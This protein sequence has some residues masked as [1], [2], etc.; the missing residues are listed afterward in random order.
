[1]NTQDRLS[2]A[3]LK[4]LMINGELP[5]EYI[6]EPNL[7]A[8]FNYELEQMGD[9][10]CYDTNIMEYCSK[11]LTEHYTD[12]SFQIRKRETFKNIKAQIKLMETQ[13]QPVI[14][15][16]FFS[17]TKRIIVASIIIVLIIPTFA[18]TA[19][20]TNLWSNAVGFTQSMWGTLLGQ[21]I[22]KDNTH[23]IASETRIYSTVEEFQAKEKI[24]LMIPT[25]LHGNIEIEKIEYIDD[26]NDGEY[27]ELIYDDEATF[28][29]VKLNATMPNT[30]GA[31]IYENNNTF[32]YVFKTSNLIWWENNNN[33]YT[34][35]CGFDISGYTEEIIKNIK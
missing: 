6:S 33:F 3:E 29:S 35:A 21:E 8:L 30:D 11:L 9:N 14:V 27:V 22:K 32:F 5:E 1:M 24:M 18:I 10:E 4:S 25:W 2:G 19:I 20:N 13:K 28:L 12:E 17:S 26:V 15:K 31:E 16:I 34:L 7:N 23:R